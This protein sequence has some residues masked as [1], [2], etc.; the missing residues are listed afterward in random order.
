MT[1]YGAAIPTFHHGS[2]PDMYTALAYKDLNPP[3][4]FWVGCANPSPTES[5]PTPH[6]E[7]VRTPPEEMESRYIWPK[8]EFD[9]CR[10]DSIVHKVCTESLPT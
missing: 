6:F 2:D 5:T 3:L 9:V 1:H 8:N 7:E 10:S 4:G